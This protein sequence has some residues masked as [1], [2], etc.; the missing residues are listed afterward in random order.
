MFWGMLIKFEYAS[1]IALIKIQMEGLYPLGFCTFNEHPN[2]VRSR[3]NKGCASINL[4]LAKELAGKALK[5]D[6]RMIV[7]QEV[8]WSGRN[9]VWGLA[10]QLN[11]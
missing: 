11:P 3:E 9:K 10:L 1:E 4:D 7:T 6:L 8:A 5:E 2:D